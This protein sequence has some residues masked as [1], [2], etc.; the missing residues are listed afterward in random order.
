MPPP[1]ASPTHP[2]PKHSSIKIVARTGNCDPLC[3]LTTSLPCD[4]I[5]SMTKPIPSRLFVYVFA[6]LLLATS[7][8][9]FSAG[10]D[11]E[12][13]GDLSDRFLLVQQGWGELGIDRCAHATGQEGL[14]LQI[15][16]KVYARGLGHHAP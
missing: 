9:T 3:G 6:A 7:T 4:G 2:K 16:Q 13:L 5:P 11:V 12:Q 15:G 14:P 10:A 1:C 8:S